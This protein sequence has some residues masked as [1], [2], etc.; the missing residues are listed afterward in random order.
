MWI[1]SQNMHGGYI[2][3]FF[4]NQSVVNGYRYT[5]THKNHKLELDHELHRDS[6]EETATYHSI[7]L[8][9]HFASTENIVTNTKL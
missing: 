3:R 1:E 7:I 4:G 2:S 6:V 9:K 5:Y 8:E